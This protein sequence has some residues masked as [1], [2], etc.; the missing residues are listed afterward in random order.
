MDW[1]QSVQS[2]IRVVDEG[3]FNGAARKMNATSSAI[4]KRIHVS[5]R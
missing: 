5:W 2:Y 4:S 1:I 3:S